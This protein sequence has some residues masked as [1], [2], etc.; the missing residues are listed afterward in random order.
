MEFLVIL[1]SSVLGLVAPVGLV[2]DRTAQNAIRSQLQQVDRLEV[3]VDNAPSHQLLQG[4]VERVRIAGR[5]LK[6]KQQD[7]RIAA[8]ELETDPIDLAPSSLGKRRLKLNRSFQ[9]GLNLVLEQQDINQALQSP[10]LRSRLRDLNLGELGSDEDSQP[11]YELVNP[12]VELLANNRLRFQVQ[13]TAANEKPDDDNSLAITVESG[14][15]VVA[16]RQIQLVKPVVYVNREAV[17]QQLV[18]EIATNFSQ[19]LDFR[20]LEVYGLQGRIL[21]LNVNPQKL[22]IVAFLKVEPSSQLLHSRLSPTQLIYNLPPHTD[23]I[24][25]HRRVL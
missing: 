7:I 14:L 11:G 15:S 18:N 25:A 17:A 8:L 22:E 23:T 12:K 24:T 1:L 16:G 21:Q 6:L 13:L 9:A 4:K 10:S 5:G 3:R 19:A 20:N 2:A